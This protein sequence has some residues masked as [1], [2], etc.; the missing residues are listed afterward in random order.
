MT[1]VVEVAKQCG[2]DR[3]DVTR[4]IDTL[5]IKPKKINNQNYITD[6]QKDRVFKNLYYN[7]KIEF[8]TFES[9][10]NYE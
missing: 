6:L 9:K 5:G 10:M 8:V 1:S 2:A 7:L 4:A 3:R